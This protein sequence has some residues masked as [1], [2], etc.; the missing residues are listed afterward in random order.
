MLIP[1]PARPMPIRTVRPITRVNVYSPTPE[2]RERYAADGLFSYWD[3]R[4]G[5][6]HKKRGMRIDFV[7]ASTSLAEL[8]ASDLV[9]RNARKGP[10]PSDHAPVLAW[11]ELD[12]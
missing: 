2:N 4:N 3:Y 1:H 5:D 9:D 10:K 12:R 8:A 11:F 7:L 6:F